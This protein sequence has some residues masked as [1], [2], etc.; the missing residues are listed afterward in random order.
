[1]LYQGAR[2]LS[3]KLYNEGLSRLQ[4]NDLYH[5]IKALNKCVAIN[6]NNIRAR[7]L[8]GLALFEC[9]HIGEALKHWVISQSLVKENNPATRYLE[10]VNKNPRVLEKLNDALVAYNQALEHLK[11]NSDDLALLQLKRAVESNPKFVDAYNLMALCLI[12]SNDRDRAA[13]MLE[14]VLAMDANNPIA[15]GYYAAIFPNRTRP[16]LGRGNAPRRPEPAYQQS[17]L[18]QPATAKDKPMPIPIEKK[19]KNFHLEA[20]VTFIIG[21]LCVV[22]AYQWLIMPGFLRAAERNVDQYRQ[23]W[24]IQEAELRNEADHLRAQLTE[25]GIEISEKLTE[26]DDLKAEI[27]LLDRTIR[28]LHAQQTYQWGDL[29]G[30][31]DALR[32]IDLEGLA[33]NILDI[34]D[35]IFSSANPQL[36]MEYYNQGLAAFNA[37]PQDRSLATVRLEQAE[38]YMAEDTVQFPRLLF[39]LGRLYYLD[40]TQHVL[41]LERLTQL[42]YIGVA[43]LTAAERTQV[44][45]MLNNLRVEEED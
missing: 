38:R 18:R 41:A 27:D 31:V 32:G 12:S 24:V 34:T 6:K 26:M 9:G 20:I 29:R 44:T 17:T 11:R 14:R 33:P 1:V 45:N 13:V 39:M 3:D 22:A 30:A 10:L 42:E 25:R 7:N 2:N 21:A 36:A 4:I 37:N 28:V 35:W 8:L 23:D 5:G 43:T 19:A 15:L 16:G 40:E